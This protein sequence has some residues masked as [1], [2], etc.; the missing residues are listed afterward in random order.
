MHAVE[1]LY[2]GL[3]L[4]IR[5]WTDLFAL[6]TDRVKQRLELFRDGANLDGRRQD[7]VSRS[8]TF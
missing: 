3:V 2:F 4:P 8:Q 5:G 7:P 6:S 1:A